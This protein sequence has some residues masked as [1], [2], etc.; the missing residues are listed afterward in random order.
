MGGKGKVL[1]LLI[2]IST[3]T[4]TIL[5]LPSPKLPHRTGTMAGGAVDH[6]T[7]GPQAAVGGNG[8]GG[9]HGNKGRA[10]RSGS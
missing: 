8:A 7:D 6:Q 1:V 9:G 2:I 5:L 10:G 4:T 3:I